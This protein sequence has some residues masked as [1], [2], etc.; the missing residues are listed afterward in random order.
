V[1]KKGSIVRPPQPGTR[2]KG[3]RRD[4]FLTVT[5]GEKEKISCLHHVRFSE[6]VNRLWT[7]QKKNGQQPFPLP[8]YRVVAPGQTGGK[9]WYKPC[10]PPVGGRRKR[11]ADFASR[12]RC[13]Q[14]KEDSPAFSAGSKEGVPPILTQGGRGKILNK[15]GKNSSARPKGYLR[16][17]PRLSPA[18]AA[19][20]PGVEEE[21]RKRTF[22]P[23][24]SCP[25][26]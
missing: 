5:R 12:C 15:S 3:G 4:P 26:K 1:E 8:Y 24:L 2:G 20:H 25:G 13:P 22:L 10:S 6:N 21:R 11:G 9:K 17:G 23:L 18:M 7:R 16:R 14:E 19:F